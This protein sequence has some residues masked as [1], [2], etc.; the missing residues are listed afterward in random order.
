MRDKKNSNMIKVNTTTLIVKLNINKYS[1]AK[2]ENVRL[3]TKQEPTI[4]CLQEI[5]SKFK[6]TKRLKVKDCKNIPCKQEAYKR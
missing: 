5:Y 4:W 1:T 6:D 2:A 3:P